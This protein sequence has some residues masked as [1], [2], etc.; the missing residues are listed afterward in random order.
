MLDF[1]GGRARIARLETRE[2][3][4][5]L[6]EDSANHAAAR[7]GRRYFHRS[8]AGNDPDRGA[9]AASVGTVPEYIELIGELQDMDPNSEDGKEI[10]STLEAL[11]KLCTK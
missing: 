3:L 6:T 9:R 8:V 7:T 4:F 2:D 5:N 1:P 10:T 11:D